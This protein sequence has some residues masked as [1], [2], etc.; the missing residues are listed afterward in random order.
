[1]NNNII[2]ILNGLLLARYSM[3]KKQISLTKLLLL[4]NNN[5]RLEMTEESLKD[6]L[7]Q[8]NI[9]G[10]IVKDKIILQPKAETEEMENIDDDIHEKAVSQAGKEMRQ[11][12]IEIKLKKK[13][14]ETLE[15][16]H[17]LKGIQDTNE[18]LVVENVIK[19]DGI[20]YYHC[21]LKHNNIYVDIP[22]N[23]F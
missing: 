7:L 16:Y 14:D 3:G 8:S 19:K 17:L 5:Y 10:D 4:V 18:T 15:N 22:K 21:K 6:I 1:M 13:L 12:S 9:V 2:D 20:I 11:E 23:I